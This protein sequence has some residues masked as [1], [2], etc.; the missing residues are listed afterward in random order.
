MQDLE[1]KV[2]KRLPDLIFFES[3]TFIFVVLSPAYRCGLIYVTKLRGG[4]MQLQD[5]VYKQSESCCSL[6]ENLVSERRETEFR[7]VQLDA[8]LQRIN[9]LSSTFVFQ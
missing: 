9:L 1:P 7:P 6:L 3:I 4:Q 5:F 8:K 2:S